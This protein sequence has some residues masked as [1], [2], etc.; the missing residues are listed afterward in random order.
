MEYN[1]IKYIREKANL[2]Q[3]KLASEIGIS[4]KSLCKLESGKT[5]LINKNV[6]KIAEVTGVTEAE[7]LGYLQ[8]G[9]YAAELNDLR[10]NLEK[11]I[12]YLKLEIADKDALIESQ[13]E[14]I[15][16]L[17]S[18]ASYLEQIINF[19]EKTINNISS[20]TAEKEND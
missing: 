15:R 18:N 8:A 17:E 5:P 16:L 4:R 3:E 14:I 9:E 19:Q 7:V 20:S 11:E 6:P 1:G 12:K 10:E 13:K 2:T